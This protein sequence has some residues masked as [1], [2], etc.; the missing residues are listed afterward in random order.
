MAPNALAAN[1]YVPV[2]RIPAAGSVPGS[3]NQM[4]AES[5]GLNEKNGH[6][7]VADSGRGRVFDFSSPTDTAPDPWTGSNTPS[8]DFGGSEGHVA[9][10]VD[11]STGDVY[12]ADKTHAVIDKFDQNGNLLS[13]YG[14]AIPSA[15]GQLHGTGTPA[16][17]F[18]PASSAFSSFGIAV[19]QSTHELY[20]LDG[21]HQVIDV[22]GQ[23]GTYLRQITASPE[24]LYNEGGVY[25]TGIAVNSASGALY[26]T[27]WAGPNKVFE[28]DSSGNYVSTWNG[29]NTPDGNFSGE[30]TG[31]YLISAAV[32]DSTGNVF[33]GSMANRAVDVFDK[34]GNFLPPQLN[35]SSLDPSFFNYLSGVAIEQSTGNLYVSSNTVDIFK[36]VIVPDVSTSAVSG[37]KPTVAT[38]NGHVDPAGG[39]G[40]SGC[41]F[42]YIADLAFRANTSSNGNNSPWTGA[43][44]APCQTSPA[45]SLPYPAPADVHADLTGLEPG[46]VYHD[47]L[48]VTNANGL[49]RST[50]PVFATD[51]AYDFSTNFGSTGS[52]DGQLDGPQDVAVNNGSGDLY[53][54]DTGNHRIVRLDSSGAFLSAWGWGVDDGTAASQVCTG[55]CQAGIAGTGAGQFDTPRFVEVDNSTGPSEG[56]VYV[57]DTADQFVQKFTAAG[58]PISTWGNNGAIEFP[59]GTIGGITVDKFGNLFV[60]SDSAPYIWTKVGQDGVSRSE[61][62]TAD[63]FGLGTPNGTGIEIDNAGGYYELQ[64]SGNGVLYRNPAGEMYSGHSVY[65]PGYSDTI[66]TGIVVDRAANDLYVAQG[67]FID[68]FPSSAGCPYH[69]DLTGLK[70]CAPQDSFG[71]GKLIAASGLGFDPTSRR[72]Y[73]ADPAADHIVVFAPHPVAEATTGA[74]T[75]SEPTAVT[76]NGHV[77]PAASE[78]VS[79]CYF[80]YGVDSTYG[81]GSVPCAQPTPIT[82][83]SDV[84]AELTGLTSLTTY[85]Y[86]LAVKSPEELVSYGKDRS[87]TPFQKL[88]P[89]IGDASASKE[90]QTT[91]MLSALINP[92]FSP[93]IYRFQYGTDTSYGEQTPS[94]ESIGEDGFDHPV[95]TEVVDLTPGTVYHFRVVA[96]NFNGPAAGPDRT[97]TTPDVPGV[98]DGSASNVGRTTAIL[99]SKVSP[100]FRSTAYKF[101]Y[102]PTAAYGLSTDSSL[103]IGSDNSPHTVG[104]EITGLAAGTTYHYRA[105]ATNEIGTTHGP[106]GTFTT[107]SEEIQ[108]TIPIEPT[109]TQ[110]KR[111]LVRKSGKC[112]KRQKKRGHRG[113]GHHKR[114]N[115]DD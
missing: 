9:V 115:R 71:F 2:T 82:A 112:V 43:Q 63:F 60:V 110:C 58:A 25:V 52:G 34:D 107:A 1:A 49:V 33:V 72:V 64:Q 3:F 51:G 104:N 38:I 55:G 57:A 14:D 111:G 10:A 48:I 36:R 79:S 16:G 4:F 54:A 103:S 88:T 11:N 85:H 68:Q 50:G 18:S 29:S 21:G 102:G 95:S 31:C 83:A 62:A 5:V 26:V 32:E 40:I 47:R 44:Q 109:T 90:G 8:G 39:G 75:N 13:G 78:P 108:T 97:F 30:C 41:Y 86:R 6:I 42:E 80:E 100:G 87:F 84:S 91:V 27:N 81:L 37:V 56:D 89:T 17:S 98:S 19:N 28:F 61:T 45:S 67:T 46:T 59:K 94:S 114:S 15:D 69:G 96:T 24:G 77:V 70:I 92:K 76:L 53:V 7:L 12:V 93:T 65:P 106:D 105:V 66:N 73:A 74:V 20:V 99:G 113:H 22:F 23:S 101:E 35:Q